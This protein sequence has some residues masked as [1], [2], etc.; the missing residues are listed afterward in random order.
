MQLDAA[1]DPEDAGGDRE[2]EKNERP[3]DSD[4]ETDRDEPVLAKAQDAA[5][6]QNAPQE[7]DLEECTCGREREP[8]AK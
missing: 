5:D 7:H 2:V 6:F 1:A 3:D 4:H 8:G